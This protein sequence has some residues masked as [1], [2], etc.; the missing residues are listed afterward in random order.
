MI[1]FYFIMEGKFEW[2][3]DNQPY[4]LYPGDTAIVL[5]GQFFGSEKGFLDIGILSSLSIQPDS[6]D[7]SGKFKLGKWSALPEADRKMLGKILAL[8]R[9]AVLS[10]LK[11]T[12]I[13][14]QKLEKELFNQEIGYTTRVNQLIDELFISIA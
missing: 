4:M 1:R 9:N 12:G 7:V 8:N 13:L 3:I 14:L 11:E 10:K 2:N 5:P 6:L